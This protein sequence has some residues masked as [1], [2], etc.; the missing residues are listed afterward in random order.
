MAD[1][2]VGG[3]DAAVAWT[4]WDWVRLSG[5]VTGFARSLAYLPQAP[6]DVL[7]ESMGYLQVQVSE[8]WFW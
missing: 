7:G 8:R 1:V 6:G 5:G 2:Y 4:P 3:F